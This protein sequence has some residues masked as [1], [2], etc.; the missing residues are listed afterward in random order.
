M[1]RVYTALIELWRIRKSRNYREEGFDKVADFPKAGLGSRTG[2]PPR[3]VGDYLA[4]DD[5]QFRNLILW[6]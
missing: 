2:V 4:G 3:N 5:W 6:R 1:R